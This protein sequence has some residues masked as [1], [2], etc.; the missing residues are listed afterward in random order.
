MARPGPRAHQSNL[1]AKGYMKP[2]R[3]SLGVRHPWLGDGNSFE[4]D[5]QYV[6]IKDHFQTSV[7]SV[8]GPGTICPFYLF[9]FF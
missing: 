2:W 5:L 4:K 7:T 9:N 3:Q 8:T 6:P 1:T